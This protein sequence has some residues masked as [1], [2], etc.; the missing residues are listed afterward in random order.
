MY[1][2]TTVNRRIGSVHIEV[3]IRRLNGLRNASYV[4]NGRGRR[5][6]HNVGCAFR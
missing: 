2:L 1:G 6:R 5:N 3:L 4:R